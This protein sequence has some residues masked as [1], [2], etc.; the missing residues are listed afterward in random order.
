MIQLSNEKKVLLDHILEATQKQKLFI[1]DENMDGL[2]NILSE[3][4]EIMKNID[5]LDINFLSL[6][7][8]IKS[9]ENIS[10]LEDINVDKYSN[11]KLLKSN[12][13]EINLMLNSIRILDNDNTRMMKTNLEN[14]KSGLKHVKEVKNAYKGYNYEPPESMLIDEKK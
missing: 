9:M 10:S 8:N 13:N 2:T 1:Q 7:N 5:L 14:I 12:I 3:K 11:I 4:D 6:Y